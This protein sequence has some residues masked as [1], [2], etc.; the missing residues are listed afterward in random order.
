[1]TKVTTFLNSQIYRL[2]QQEIDF[3]NHVTL[4]TPGTVTLANYLN[5]ED[6]YGKSASK[7]D[8]KRISSSAQGRGVHREHL[9]TPFLA[10]AAGPSLAGV[11]RGDRGWARLAGVAGGSRH[12][13]LYFKILNYM[14]FLMFFSATP[15]YPPMTMAG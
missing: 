12:L 8:P 15:C 4:V 1:V 10:M 5:F 9:A 3:I 11:A 14:H 7:S 2:K 6:A 13:V